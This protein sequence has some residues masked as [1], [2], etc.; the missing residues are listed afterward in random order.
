MIDAFTKFDYCSSGEQPGK[1]NVDNKEH[2]SQF[3]SSVRFI[4]LHG[5]GSSHESL[6]VRKELKPLPLNRQPAHETSQKLQMEL[7]TG[8]DSQAYGADQQQID[9]L[10]EARAGSFSSHKEDKIRSRLAL[11]RQDYCMRCKLAIWE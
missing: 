3:Y 9:R 6:E 8:K 7:T 2:S 5:S 10:V 1:D 11:D 4:S